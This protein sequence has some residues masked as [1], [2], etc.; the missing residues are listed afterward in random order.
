MHGGLINRRRIGPQLC[1][2]ATEGQTTR[3][4]SPNLAVVQL[5]M[6]QWL[7]SGEPH[8]MFDCLTKLTDRAYLCPYWARKNIYHFRLHDTNKH[9]KGSGCPDTSSRSHGMM[10]SS[11]APIIY[12]VR[13]S[14]LLETNRMCFSFPWSAVRLPSHSR[15]WLGFDWFFIKRMRWSGI[16]IIGN[17]TNMYYINGKVLSVRYNFVQGYGTWLTAKS[18][19]CDVLLKYCLLFYLTWHLLA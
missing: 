13:I 9:H 12:L 8:T 17:S 4:R 18:R 11:L 15:R 2:N 3:R 19:L 10:C 5:F 1:S 16:I 7:S 6:C 14:S